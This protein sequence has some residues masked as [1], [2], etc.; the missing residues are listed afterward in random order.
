MEITQDSNQY[1][2]IVAVKFAHSKQHSLVVASVY[3]HTRSGTTPP[4][5]YAWIQKLL[6]EANVVQVIIVGDFNAKSDIRGIL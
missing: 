3:Y 1:R 6:H 2:E 4:H 5:E